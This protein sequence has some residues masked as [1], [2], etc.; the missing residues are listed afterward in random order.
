MSKYFLS[1][2]TLLFIALKLLGP[3]A[4][5][6]SIRRLEKKGDK[7]RPL[8][9]EAHKEAKAKARKAGFRSDR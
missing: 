6:S 1:A 5:C 9:T 3:T 7:Y 4:A 2:L 8:P